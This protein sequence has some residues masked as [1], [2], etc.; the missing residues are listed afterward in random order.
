MFAALAA[1]LLLPAAPAMAQLVYRWVDEKG[2]VHYD[3]TLPAEYA[4]RPHQ[5]LQNGIVIRSI[6]DPTAPEPTLEQVQKEKN[7]VDPEIAAHEKQMRA[8]RLLVLKYRS[9]EEI[10]DAM[11]VEVDNL[12]Y[13]ARLIEQSR[14]SVVASLNGQ[15]REAADRQRAGL[16]IDA[17]ISDE[18]KQLRGRLRQGARSKANLDKREAQIREIFM[19]ELNR[20]RYLNGDGP[21]DEATA[22]TATGENNT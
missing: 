14:L 18:I 10:L 9:E 22:D 5:I 11:Q 6:D 3:S 8:D 15:I 2:E 21:E 19:S 12:A 16:P 1:C 4:N 13:D 20:Y 7:K 17:T